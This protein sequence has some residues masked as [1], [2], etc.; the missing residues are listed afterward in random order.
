MSK[1]RYNK[2]AY[3]KQVVIVFIVPLVYLNTKIF[4]IMNPISINISI[5]VFFCFLSTI[6]ILPNMY[7]V[8]ISNVLLNSSLKISNNFL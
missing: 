2:D 7:N 4:M 8:K 5:N 6:T 1:I 3:S